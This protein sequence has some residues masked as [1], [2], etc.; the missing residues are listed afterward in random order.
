MK[1]L[2]DEMIASIQS[3][4]DEDFVVYILTGLDKELYNSL[5]STIITCVE[6]ISP[7]ELFS[8][9]LSYELHLEK[10]E[11]GRATPRNLQQMLLQEGMAAPTT[12]AEVVAGPV[13][14]AGAQVPSLPVAATI[15]TTLGA[16]LCLLT[17]ID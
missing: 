5:V 13:T 15:T 9:M 12:M 8:Q 7:F 17:R 10:Q 1:N 4:S 11:G 3:L 6:P 2:A 16:L 14:L